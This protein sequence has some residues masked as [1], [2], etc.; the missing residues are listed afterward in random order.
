MLTVI[1]LIAQTN[2]EV[3]QDTRKYGTHSGSPG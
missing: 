2:K 3:L 1:L